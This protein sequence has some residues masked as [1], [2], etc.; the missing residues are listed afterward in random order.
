MPSLTLDAVAQPGDG[1]YQ[2]GAIALLDLANAAPE[3]CPV[4]RIGAA[5]GRAAVEYVFKRL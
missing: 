5:A 2:P 1:R 4:G 3:E